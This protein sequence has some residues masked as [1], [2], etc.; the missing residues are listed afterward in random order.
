[1]KTTVEIAGDLLEDARAL[2]RSE[3]T[4][5]RALV[6]EGLRTV[7]SRRKKSTEQFTLKDAGASGR[8]VQQGLTEGDWNELRDL[9]YRGRGS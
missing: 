1:M 7:L 8:G 4:T 2:A 6:E 9:I 3:R 5:L